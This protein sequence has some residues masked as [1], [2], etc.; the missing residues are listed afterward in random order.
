MFILRSK[1]RKPRE[2]EQKTLFCDF[3]FKKWI[4]QVH[5]APLPE[6]RNGEVDV[7]VAALTTA[8]MVRSHISYSHSSIARCIFDLFFPRIVWPRPT[9]D[10]FVIVGVMFIETSTFSGRVVTKPLPSRDCQSK[11]ACEH[12][13]YNASCEGSISF[14]KSYAF[15]SVWLWKEYTHIL[16]LCSMPQAQIQL[17]TP[18]LQW[19]CGHVISLQEP[20]AAGRKCPA[21]AEFEYPQGQLKGSTRGT[22]VLS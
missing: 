7:K 10:L 5:G 4:D 20:V 3:H 17:F 19:R 16:V 1:N 13:N 22:R 9:C 21:A 6:Q 8:E 15:D 18:V 11:H 2:L 14:R 12:C